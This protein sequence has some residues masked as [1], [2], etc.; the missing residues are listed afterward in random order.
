MKRKISLLLA[1]TMILSM[2]TF[3]TA[4]AHSD[5]SVQINGLELPF[6]D[7][8]P[9]IRNSRTLVPLRAIFEALGAEVTWDDATKTAIG[10]L[11][12]T[13]IKIAIG[14][15]EGYVN[16]QA[17][18]LDS[19]AALINS[20]TMVPVRF[21]AESLGAKV[22][23]D[24]EKRIV[25]IEKDLGKTKDGIPL[26]IAKGVK[27]PV[28]TEFE[29]SSEM[30]AENL[31]YFEMPETADEKYAKL[32]GG[33]VVMTTEDFL[34]PYQ[35]QGQDSYGGG[36]YQILEENGETFIRHR[37]VEVPP[38][39]W[40]LNYRV[41]LDEDF[42]KEFED[43]DIV[44]L[45]AK[46]RLYSG[47]NIDTKMGKLGVGFYSVS[48]ESPKTYDF[49]TL[50]HCGMGTVEYDIGANDGWK[51]IYC[52]AVLIREIVDGEKEK[53]DGSTKPYGG[54]RVHFVVSSMIQEID[55]KDI[56]VENFG[57]KYDWDAMP[58]GG[59]RYIGSE[60]DAQWRK[61]ALAKIEQVRK[62]D[63]KVVVKD[64]NGNVI[65]DAQ[66]NIDMF[67]HEFEFSGF[68][69][70]EWNAAKHGYT[71]LEG[72]QNIKLESG[73]VVD[74]SKGDAEG[75]AKKARMTYISNFN[76]VG[77]TIHKKTLN[78]D[79]NKLYDV[80][81]KFYDWAD[82]IGMGDSLKGHT[83]IWDD[84]NSNLETGYGSIFDGSEE[85]VD[86][87]KQGF[88]DHIKYMGQK[89]PY[90]TDV[91]VTNEDGGRI[92]N[93]ACVVKKLYPEEVWKPIWVEMYKT[94][95]E[96]FPNSKLYMSDG[97]QLSGA[98]KEFQEKFMDWA[99]E[100][101]DFDAWGQH[102][103]LSYTSSPESIMKEYEVFEKYNK[104][105][106]ITEFD[107]Y[108]GDDKNYQANLTRDA[109]IAHFSQP[110]CEKIVVFTVR[111]FNSKPEGTQAIITHE[112]FSLKPSGTVYQDLVYNKWW[113]KEN[114]TTNENGEFSTRGFFGDYTI[115]AKA[116]GKTAR[117]DVHLGKDD[118]REVVIVIE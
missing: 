62:G 12:D 77:T 115:T 33:Q 79:D 30:T 100:N 91:D 5:I 89:M 76:G 64:I 21:V 75:T 55:I 31:L 24:N 7:Q 72:I 50:N 103:H 113:T 23:W 63:I 41:K 3:G 116:N 74:D 25:L 61:D 42:Q 52:P 44:L 13:T 97:R 109:L 108:C 47:G 73:A 28:P 17:V 83:L 11:G 18:A 92:I 14:A 107:I 54:Y 112:D 35:T 105:V 53:S 87:I 88:I 9:V 46:A 104:P 36:G 32:S 110:L 56:K 99:V 114:G 20:R 19:G 86:K 27:R 80:A 98:Q 101:L 34:N 40:E 96:A 58:Q 26:D 1:V 4:F 93:G 59:G 51:N 67:E 29:K 95:R 78:E 65:P 39:S 8:G 38:N 45:S 10:T 49:T 68:R 81:R 102:G 84:N 37:C 71:M 111:D 43:G 117:C 90:L 106:A 94:A 22:D 2:F 60:E 16:E 48:N 82:A 15:N 66:V 85:N 69:G 57:T 70:H 118:P 6:F